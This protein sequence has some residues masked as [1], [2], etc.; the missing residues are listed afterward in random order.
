VRLEIGEEIIG[1][2]TEYARRA[3]VRCGGLTGIGACAEA[4]LGFFHP[5]RREYSRRAF[6]G[7]H[8]IVALT[9]NFSEL[10]GGPFPHCHIVL[11]DAAFACHAGH[12]FRAV[13]TVTAEIQVVTDPG[14]LRRARRPDLGFNPLEPA[15]G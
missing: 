1:S 2:L 11:G 4:E 6:P 10:D 15:E 14:V 13:V 5:E 3:G 12:L 7:D 9:G 8:E